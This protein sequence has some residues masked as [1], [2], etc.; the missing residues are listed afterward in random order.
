MAKKIIKVE[1]TNK[2]KEK[3]KKN[4]DLKKI[5]TYI[6]ENKDTIEKVVDLVGDSLGTNT[7]RTKTTKSSR[8]TT[9]SKTKSKKSS[10]SVMDLFGNLFK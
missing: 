9:K 6:V 1:E 7:K 4:I 8:K 3:K 5:G 2:E 10:S